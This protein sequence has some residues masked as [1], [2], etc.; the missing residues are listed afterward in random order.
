MDYK[1]PLT[2]EIVLYK[3]GASI[4]SKTLAAP[5]VSKSLS[6]SLVQKNWG[7]DKA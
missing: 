6:L 2:A 1:S 5:P 7:A 3:A 4:E